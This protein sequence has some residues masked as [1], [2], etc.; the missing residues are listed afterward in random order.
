MEMDEM[1][2]IGNEV[3]I[4]NDGYMDWFLKQFPDETKSHIER[5]INHAEP[6]DGW[7]RVVGFNQGFPVLRGPLGQLN[8]VPFECITE[9]RSNHQPRGERD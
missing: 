5:A 7:W 8:Q 4:S 6:V 2:K 3:K 1:I 9:H